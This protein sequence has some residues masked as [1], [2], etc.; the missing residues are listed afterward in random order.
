MMYMPKRV[1]EEVTLPPV[2]RVSMRVT[3]LGRCTQITLYSQAIGVRL[4][5]GG[6]SR[7]R[8]GLWFGT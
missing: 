8:N 1:Q 3:A 2:R 5:R 6:K 7:V 4:G